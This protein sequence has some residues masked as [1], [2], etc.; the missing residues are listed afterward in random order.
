MAE[1]NTYDLHADLKLIQPKGRI[2]YEYNPLHNYRLDKDYNSTESNKRW[3]NLVPLEEG[4]ITEQNQLVDFV[5]EELNFDLSHPVDILP[6]YSYDGTVN[7]SINDGKNQ[8]RLI[9]TR[10]TL[11]GK[12]TYEV[13][14]R[15]GNADANIYDRGEQFLIDT[16][17]YKRVQKIP[18]LEFLGTTFGGN[19]SVGNYHFY[20]KFSDGDDNE[21]DFVAESGLVSVFIGENPFNTNTGIVQENSYK[22]VR[23]LMSN[24]D[25]AYPYVKVYY[26]KSTADYD[27]HLVTSA[28]YIDKKFTVNNLHN[29]NILITG[30]ETTIEI[31]H[32]E[33]NYRYELYDTAETQ[34]ICQNRLFLGNLH[35]P[36]I[37]YQELQDISLRFYPVL[38]TEPYECSL[39]N[40]YLGSVRNSYYDPLTIYNKVGYW[41]GEIYRFGIVY[42]LEDG[43]L[44]PVFNI[45]G[46]G[47][48]GRG[49]EFANL[50]FFDEDGKRKYIT[51]SEETHKIEDGISYYENCKGVCRI[52]DTGVRNGK[53]EIIYL[54]IELQEIEKQAT[55]KDFSKIGK[56]L[57]VDLNKTGNPEAF[58][59][60]KVDLLEILRNKFK[61]KG[62]FF[63]RQQRIPTTMCQA[64]TIGIDKNS[65]TPLIPRGNE[66]IAERFIDDQRILSSNFEARLYRYAESGAD[67]SSKNDVAI[68]GAICP[69]YDVNSSYYN[70][71]FTGDKFVCE[72]ARKITLD[73][74]GDERHIT[75]QS[76]PENGS[77]NLL[78]ENIVG[79]EDSC[80]IV[81]VNKN[82]WSAQA[83]NAQEAYTLKYLVRD[84]KTSD[85]TNI[86][87]G[88]FGPFIGLAGDK[89]EACRIL[90]IKAPGY[91][92]ANSDQYM[93]IRCCDESPFFSV[94]DRLDITRLHTSNKK[95]ILGNNDYLGLYRGDCYICK[96]THRVNRNFQD[97]EVPT[98]DTI[99][100]QFCWKEYYNV[101]EKEKFANI[102]RGDVNAVQLGIWVTFD[103]RSSR[104]LNVRTLDISNVTEMSIVGHPRTFYPHT[105]INASAVYNVP[106]ALKYNDG[107]TKS[108]ANR[109]HLLVPDVPYILNM[110]TNRIAYSEI[111]V[112][113][114]IKNGFRV[115][116]NVNYRDYNMEHGAIVK[117]MEFFGNLI[118]VFEHGI[119]K[120][121]V[122]EKTITSQGTNGPVFINSNNVLPQNIVILSGTFGSQWKDSILKT[123]T[124][125][126]GV[127]T[128]AKKI[129]R[130][131]GDNVEIISE[132]SLQRFL[133][134]NITLTERDKTPIM[135]IR[136]VKTHYN[137][138]KH[139]VMFTFYNSKHTFDQHAWNVCWNE[140]LQKWITFYSWL[141]SASENIHNI[142]FT[143]DHDVE[144]E[145]AKLS[146]SYKNS[147]DADGICLSKNVLEG[148]ENT[149]TL[150]IENRNLPKYYETEYSIEH[151]PF[152]NYKIF[153]FNGQTRE[154][155]SNNSQANE[156]TKTEVALN[157]PALENNKVYLLYIKATVYQCDSNGNEVSTYN[158][159]TNVVAITTKTHVKK[160]F[161]DFWKHGQGGIMDQKEK[162][163]P[164]RWFGKNHPFEFE[165]VVA[166]NPHVQKI[167]NNLKIISNNVAPESF[168]YEIVGD[169]YNF[170][171]LQYNAN[172]D[173]TF[174]KAEKKNMY[175][176]Q[177]AT[178]D[179][180]RYNGANID[181]DVEFIDRFRDPKPQEQ[182]KAPADTLQQNFKSTIF[183]LYYNRLDVIN[184]I[185]DEY[186]Q[187]MEDNK[188]YSRMSGGEIAWDELLNEFKIIVHAKAEDIRKS[189]RIQGNMHYKED[190][191]DIQINPLVYI[192]KNENQW[193]YP[194]I[195]P[196]IFPNTNVVDAS[197][198]T[199]IPPDLANLGY[200]ET[201]QLVS[202]SGW[203]GRK[204][205]KL[206]DKFI[207][208]KVR[209]Y[210]G[211]DK[212]LD[213]V[214][215][216][217]IKTL[218][219]ISY[220]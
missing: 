46:T 178:K 151:D 95:L 143:F 118:C 13:I 62:F 181:Y 163:L 146:T 18:D 1:Q 102:N 194:P 92:L 41:P 100:D 25:A 84:T 56:Y 116:K 207:K 68:T 24:I 113:K 193:N 195:N 172:D 219:T 51:Y 147:A 94:T 177:E 201:E 11:T 37:D 152:N 203:T 142:W 21:T 90:N 122:N 70:S 104:N 135:G 121:P 101:N 211:Q 103:V 149:V 109:Q 80:P 48:L 123:A 87:R 27:Q 15:K 196:T 220:A 138:F 60:Y 158:T 26:T 209:Y 170:N 9:N 156:I 71:F 188:D 45:R 212:N 125:I 61:I 83:G 127:D 108:V 14:D 28:Y 106:E 213:L 110:F 97:P 120:I 162:I 107:F 174:S 155:I 217:A 23:F 64:L 44:S 159:Y 128:V 77:G 180:Y 16:S 31:S 124:Y 176:R 197:Q 86:I 168:H 218:Y 171:N 198:V 184:Q 85:A 160:L 175:F 214:V 111:S 7:L 66:F 140:I 141:P 139:D 52:T 185:Y 22:A 192:Q 75:E 154:Q 67:A 19:L 74:Y 20:F 82:R 6:Q 50:D 76:N 35:K 186:V 164:S 144:Y 49:T 208:I 59:T 63:V 73:Q 57:N 169:S 2:V 215:V 39:N 4:Q 191:W 189:G 179:L 98:N 145:I 91:S 112:D 200:G 10:F 43:S 88:D 5:T 153:S 134:D 205:T 78:N 183:P 187:L 17:L 132:M 89:L 165:F 40:E 202:N 54:Q 150:S 12:D 167:F 206:R 105:D 190:L 115:F 126:Y 137:N 166:D 96:F 130:T 32:D 29:C 129:W 33:I 47:N 114:S 119:A 30:S 199:S 38:K 79:V 58:P 72:E 3:T 42:I 133:N 173:N 65:Y 81:G 157:I 131:N 216:Q 204:E 210:N 55:D 69:D 34:A 93:E 99:L 136:N 53:D 182:F 117:I 148:N 8:P 161:T 36:D